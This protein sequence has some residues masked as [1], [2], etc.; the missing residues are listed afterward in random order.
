MPRT[1]VGVKLGFKTT[2]STYTNLPNLFGV[3]SLG[4]SPSAIDITTLTDTIEKKMPGIRSYG[5]S[6][7]FN[8]FYDAGESNSS[9]DALSALDNAETPTS[10]RVTLPDGTAFDF[11][12]F[13]TV[14][15]S[16]IEGNDAI[17]FTA[18]LMPQSAIDIKVADSE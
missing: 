12:A 8:F 7:D 18:S 2:G 14:S 10:F 4:G 3:P 16:E 11:T 17:K 1:T 15:L 6:L 9:F 5:D 13:V